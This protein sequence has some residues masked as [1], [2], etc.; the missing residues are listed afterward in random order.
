MYTNQFCP[1]ICKEKTKKLV[2]DVQ[3]Q[4]DG[5][6][7]AKDNKRVNEVYDDLKENFPNPKD[8]FIDLVKTKD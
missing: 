8:S 2:T 7:E 5:T 3:A 1:G 6:E 4:T